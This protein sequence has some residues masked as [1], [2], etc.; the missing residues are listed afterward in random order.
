MINP[1]YPGVYVREESSGARAVAGV[2]TS[3]T[4]FVGMTE[5]GPLDTPKQIFNLPDYERNFGSGSAGGEML[6]QVKLFFD[7]GGGEAFVT[8]IA[9]GAQQAT[10]TVRDES[11]TDTL[12]FVAKEHGVSGNRVR[13]EISYDS[14]SPESRFNLRLYRRIVS[15]TGSVSEENAEV[16]TNLS[17]NPDDPSYIKSVVDVQSE[18]VTVE[19]LAAAPAA[20]AESVLYTGLIYPNTAN[21][22]R[23][24]MYARLGLEGAVTTATFDFQIRIDQSQPVGVSVTLNDTMAMTPLATA[25]ETAINT[26]LSADGSAA[27]INFDWDNNPGQSRRHMIVRCADHSF[28][29]IPGTIN[30][31]TAPLMLTESQGAI[32]LDRFGP[33]R[34]A[35]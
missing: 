24:D 33:T 34:P 21:D 5:R 31:L 8:R 15:T 12:E 16:F 6:P 11:G 2:A 7:N 3:V 4:A 26:A 18:L 35:P 13:A 22:A 20:G 28:E 23:D 9:N 29:F 30:D 10:I 19:N 14:I 25:I 27:T 1:T 17:M 32:Y